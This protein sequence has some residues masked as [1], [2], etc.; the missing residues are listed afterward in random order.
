M[1]NLLSLNFWF[2]LR[3][4][5]MLPIWQKVFIAFLVVL[6]IAAV[7]LFL[8]KKKNKNKLYSRFLD[9][10]YSFS[11]TNLA[12]GMIFWFFNYEMVPF[13]SARF[14]FLFW[15]AEMAVWAFFMIKALVAVPKIKEQ[16][17][18]EKEF[19]KYIP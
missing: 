12:I 14:W 4:G 6:A 1:Q 17:E 3:P 2:K 7:G 15:G 19:K 18:K 13:L 11:L 16:M 10:F 8:A 9:G 5:L